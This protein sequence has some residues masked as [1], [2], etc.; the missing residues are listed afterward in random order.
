VDYTYDAR[1]NLTQAVDAY[2]TT[3]F[4]YN[5]DDYLTRI[6]YPGGR[7]LQFTYDAA[8]R[9][10]SSLDQ[11]GH[12]LDYH[13]DAA[14]RLERMTDETA[15]QVVQYEYD[16]AGRLSRKTVGNGVYTTYEYDA[17]GQLLQL[18]NHKPDDTVL[19]RFDYTYDSRG[20]R[21]SMD[22]HYGL[23]TYGY[24][25][26]G[27]LVH[28][29]L[30][31]TDPGIPD[32]DLTYVYDALG[33]RIYTLVNGVRE[34]YVTNNMN[35]YAEV[36]D[37][38]YTFDAIGSVH[39]LTTAA[40]AVANDYSYDPFGIPLESS[41]AISNPFE[42]VGQFGAIKDGSILSHMRARYYDRNLGR[43]SSEDSLMSPGKD[44]YSQGRNNPVS[45]IDPLGLAPCAGVDYR[46]ALDRAYP[47][48][49]EERRILENARWYNPIDYIRTPFLLMTAPKA[50]QIKDP[51]DIKDLRDTK[52]QV[53]RFRSQDS[54]LRTQVSRLRTPASRL[55]SPA[56]SLRPPAHF[57]LMS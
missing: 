45:L 43:F 42:F 38:T 32:Q 16:A 35:Q 2:G 56:S 11:L 51:R 23:W 5:S 13:Y 37:R 49:T 50:Y 31:S 30:A 41:E 52:L 26:T 7:W 28:A 19:S 40:G 20:R 1:G 14:G 57:P 48:G 24:D 25:D 3:A 55:Q 6:A 36:G 44:G 46:R 9:R 53:S 33:N 17:T 21:T 27:H 10:A 22:T 47:R 4:T 15:A 18:V 39:E 12:R 8:G 29:V 34:D 54:R